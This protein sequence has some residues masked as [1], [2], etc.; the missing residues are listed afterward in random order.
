MGGTRETEVEGGE[1]DQ[2]SD[3]FRTDLWH[4]HRTR[5][6]LVLDLCLADMVAGHQLLPG[7]LSRMA[8][9]T[10][11]APGRCLGHHA[12]CERSAA[13][14]RTLGRGASIPRP[15][16]QHRDLPLWRRVADRW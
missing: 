3:P 8:R 5:L 7:C 2:A 12:L 9:F 16:P 4:L 11:L 14:A 15:S 13:R 10:V 1:D 6:F